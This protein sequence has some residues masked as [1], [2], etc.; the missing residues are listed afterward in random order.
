MSPRLASASGP[1]ATAATHVR[2]RVDGGTVL[3]D[4]HLRPVGGPALGHA[5]ERC[6]RPGDHG[7]TAALGTRSGAVS[8]PLRRRAARVVTPTR[9]GPVGSCASSSQGFSS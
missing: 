7:T 3:L 8:R 6:G 1:R 5:Y 4:G 9:D 2:C